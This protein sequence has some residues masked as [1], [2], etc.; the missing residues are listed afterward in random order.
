[1]KFNAIVNEECTQLTRIINI[2]PT[3]KCE[4]DSCLDVDPKGDERDDWR[5][6]VLEGLTDNNYF[7]IKNSKNYLVEYYG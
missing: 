7:I 3:Y 6:C 1:M 4:C 2:V 5:E